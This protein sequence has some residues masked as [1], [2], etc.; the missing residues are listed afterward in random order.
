MF[1]STDDFH[2]MDHISELRKKIAAEL[3]Q[4]EIALKNHRSLIDSLHLLDTQLQE[5]VSARLQLTTEHRNL[6]YALATLDIQVDEIKTEARNLPDRVAIFLHQHQAR[7]QNIRKLVT[8]A[9]VQQRAISRLAH[10]RTCEEQHREAEIKLLKKAREKQVWLAEKT[11]QLFEQNEAVTAERAAYDREAQ[12]LQEMVEHK[13]LPHIEEQEKIA[14]FNEIEAKR[15]EVIRREQE[16]LVE[17][18]AEDVR[19]VEEA[20]SAVA[21]SELAELEA[22]CEAM[23]RKASDLQV[24][25]QEQEKIRMLS[26]NIGDLC[27]KPPDWPSI[28]YKTVTRINIAYKAPA[29]PIDLSTMQCD[30]SAFNVTKVRTRLKFALEGPWANGDFR[31]VFHVKNERGKEYVGKIFILRRGLEKDTR[32]AYRTIKMAVLAEQSAHA[33]ESVVGAAM[34]AVKSSAKN[35]RFDFCKGFLVEIKDPMFKSNQVEEKTDDL[36]CMMIED[37]LD[38]RL[39]KK[40]SGFGVIPPQKDHAE[41][42]TITRVCEVLDAFSHWSWHA[43]NRRFMVVDHQGVYTVENRVHKL[44]LT[45]PVSIK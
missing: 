36:T 37:K 4:E 14:L 8:L 15:R 44:K 40:M 19:R 24:R 12:E 41:G 33:F 18:F 32:C 28:R 26:N 1:L 9:L 23:F 34:Q 2:I 3:D 43:S 5:A 11:K 30:D 25:V 20:S 42:R 16:I 21:N 38:S 39:Y 6:E 22:Q 7:R 17:G 35:W 13:L 27:L 29:G 31:C 45:D 10:M